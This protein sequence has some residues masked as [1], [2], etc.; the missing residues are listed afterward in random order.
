MGYAC[1]V[2]GDPQVD[3]RHLANH[4]AF[5][6][7]LHREDHEAWLDEHAPG[8]EDEGEHELAERVADHAEEAE[9]PQVFEDTTGQLDS[10]AA[11]EGDHERSGKLFEHEGHGHDH[12]HLGHDHGADTAH[13]YQQADVPKDPETQEVLEEA[14]ELTRE[15]L[16]EDDADDEAEG[17]G[18]TGA[19]DDSD[20]TDA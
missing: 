7:M 1:P 17:E 4:L 9:F 13:G 8:W 19:A 2:C 16:R 5:T 11:A 15:M 12:D 6:A 20:D 18:D 3:A 14:R 10:E